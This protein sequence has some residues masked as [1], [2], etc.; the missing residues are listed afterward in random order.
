M[1]LIK[2]IRR[3]CKNIHELKKV[4]NSGADIIHIY[5]SETANIGDLSCAPHLY[6]KELQ[7]NSSV[8]DICNFIKTP[9]LENKTIILGGG[10]LFLSFFDKYTKHILPLAKNN[11]LII[12]GCGFDNY[13]GQKVNDYNFNGIHKVG[14]RDIG[15]SYDWLPCVSCLS[16]LFDV[17]RN[18][19]PSRKKG[20]YLHAD[21][22]KPILSIIGD[23]SY[24]VNSQIKSFED[25][26]KFIADHEIIYTN[27]YHGMY[28]ATL[29][30]RKVCILPWF[31]KKGQQGFTY[32]FN[33]FK[34]KHPV[35]EDIS[36]IDKE[37]EFNV[38]LNSLAECRKRNYDFYKEI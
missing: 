9:K 37:L 6:F 1:K 15:S 13:L 28:W 5:K 33:H 14:I 11:K 32:K 19:K 26:I 27:S 24:I 12:W 4:Q 25:S 29:L 2:K 34:Y 38:Y 3:Y 17:Y 22:S 35:L 18:H 7:Q 30:G 21:Y 20:F 23:H 10:S 16:P 31:D 36:Q 8:V